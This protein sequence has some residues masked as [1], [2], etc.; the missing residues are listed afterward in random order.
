MREKIKNL[1]NYSIFSKH[2]Q[3]LLGVSTLF[4]GI[5]HLDF[6]ASVAM[7]K[8]PVMYELVGML[9][10][11]VEIFL[12]LSGIGL[13]FAYSK[14]PEFKTYYFKR[15][16]SVY[17]V[18]LIINL[19]YAYFKNFIASQN[20][21]RA[22]LL[23]ELS[24]SYWTRPPGETRPGW[25]VV[26]IMVIYLIY[27]L[28]FRIINFFEAKKH[29]LIFTISA[30]TVILCVSIYLNRNYSELYSVVE[31]GLSRIPI[32]LISCYIGKLVYKKEK[33]GVGLYLLM[34]VGAAIK[35]LYFASDKRE[36]IFN[37]YS[38]CLLSI[39][40][41][42]I[43]I[44]FAELLIPEYIYKALE[45][46]GTMSLE[47]YLTHNLLKDVIKYYGFTRI[48]HYFIMLVISFFIS[49]VISRIRMLAVNKYLKN[50]EQKKAVSI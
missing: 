43:L 29:D 13:Y 37:R 33:I 3:F 31:I 19:P 17:F 48:R 2:R 25:Y 14:K 23:N 35:A 27:P 10:I 46:F 47:F 45:F 18:F 50:K 1:S 8:H 38:Q 26:F 6:F 7:H 24:L 34:F 40:V 20:G 4:I 16:I 11:G 42:Y 28:I 44:I 41:A 15:V 30:C 21:F 5:F 12:L 36:L 9:N 22:F 32:F 49:L 39:T